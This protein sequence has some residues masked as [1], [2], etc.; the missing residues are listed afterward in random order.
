LWIAKA[1]VKKRLIL[2]SGTMDN[3]FGRSGHFRPNQSNVFL[4]SLTT[5]KVALGVLA[6]FYAQERYCWFAIRVCSWWFDS[7]T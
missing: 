6:V 3:G 7:A 4:V 5:P 2:V 1:L